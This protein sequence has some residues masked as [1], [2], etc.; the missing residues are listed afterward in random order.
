L[1]NRFGNLKVILGGLLLAALS[2]MLFLRV[3]L[4][5]TYAAMFPSMILLGL[6]FSLAYG[7][8][9]IL[10]TDG[11]DESEQGL[12]GGLV[13]TAF[14]FGAALGLSAA[15]AV[16]MLALG[17]ETLPEARLEA[18]R[19]ALLVPVAATLIGVAVAVTGLRTSRRTT[20]G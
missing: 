12:A 15:S 10:A 1:V 3:S 7:P 16:G 17:T 2:Y 19:L 14:Q 9:T 20:L 13:N 11:I 18:M 5:W 6:A 4:D 8:L